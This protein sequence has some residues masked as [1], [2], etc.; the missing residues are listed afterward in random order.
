MS[1]EGAGLIS[2]PLVAA[3]LE[4]RLRPGGR[5]AGD[6]CFLRCPKCDVQAAIRRS[7]RLTPTTTQMECHCTNTACGHTFRADIVFVHSISEG[8]IDRPDLDLPVCP[9]EQ[10]THIVPAARDGPD[11]QV[12]MFEPPAS[13]SEAIGQRETASS[14]EAIGQTENP[15]RPKAATG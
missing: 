11:D 1:G 13:S 5:S 2:G 14:S 10:R 6:G 15:E 8:N 4:F 7:D 9:R 3:P 12:S